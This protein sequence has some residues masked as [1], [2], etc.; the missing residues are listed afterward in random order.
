MNFRLSIYIIQD[1]NSSVRRWIMDADVGF[2]CCN[3]GSLLVHY[4]CCISQ[5][6]LVIFPNEIVRSFTILVSSVTAPSRNKSLS[7]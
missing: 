1:S 2:G 3:C 7:Y 6:Y 5:Y 4:H